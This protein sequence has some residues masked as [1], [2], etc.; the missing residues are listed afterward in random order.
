LFG[1]AVAWMEDQAFLTGNTPTRPKGVLTSGALVQTADR[2]SATAISFANITNC[3]V[4]ALAMSQGTGIFLA[5]QAAQPAVMAATGTSGSVFVPA[6]LV[7]IT[8]DG[9]KSAGY[10][11]G[12]FSRP[13]MFTE[14][15]PALNTLGDF[16]FYDFSQY[17]IGDSDM[18][19]EIAVSDQYLFPVNQTMFRVIHYVGGMPWMDAGITLA[20]GSTTVSP[21]VALAIH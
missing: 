8:Q 17:L 2:G 13:I 5:S 11:I 21:F 14:K 15:L 6:G 4:K 18:G 1:R 12:A 3:W 9:V 10:G 16:G 20:D 19:M 7:P